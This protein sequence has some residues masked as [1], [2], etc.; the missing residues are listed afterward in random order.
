[1]SIQAFEFVQECHR[2]KLNK[3]RKQEPNFFG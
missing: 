1:M 2:M 3:K